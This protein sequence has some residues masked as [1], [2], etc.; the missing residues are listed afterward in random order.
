MERFYRTID[1]ATRVGVSKQQVYR[2]IKERGFLPA[3]KVMVCG[4]EA[5][6][7]DEKTVQEIEKYFLEKRTRKNLLTNDADCDTVR[8]R[9]EAPRYTCDVD[10][11]D[12]VRAENAVLYSVLLEQ[13]KVLKQ[14][15]HEKDEQIRSLIEL[16]KSLEKKIDQAQKLHIMDKQQN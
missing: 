6:L 8:N 15:L 3:D 9:N 16:S 13:M 5:Y 4:K 12:E 1:I 14:Q 10:H 2:Y 7:Y 11:N